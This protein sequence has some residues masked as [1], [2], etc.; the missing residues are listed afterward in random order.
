MK[1]LSK[2]NN[3][4]FSNQELSN[5]QKQSIKGGDMTAKSEP[6]QTNSG[7]TFMYTVFVQD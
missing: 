7:V 6:R 5:I 1:K 3:D 2:L 4:L